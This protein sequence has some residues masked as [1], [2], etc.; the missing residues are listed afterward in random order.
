MKKTAANDKK[1]RD[2]TAYSKFTHEQTLF[3]VYFKGVKRLG[4]LSVA[5]RY[6]KQFPEDQ[7]DEKS[8]FNRMHKEGV[9]DAA[10]VLQEYAGQLARGNYTWIQEEDI[11]MLGKSSTLFC[12]LFTL[13]FAF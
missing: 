12:C 2:S 10:E 6:R 8:L 13:A 11:E 9:K 4:R 1:K 5:T 7:R 3:L